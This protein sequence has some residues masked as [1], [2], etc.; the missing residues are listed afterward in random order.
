MPF[1]ADQRFQPLIEAI[2]S[3]HLQP[4]WV[5]SID[6]D[7]DP[8]VGEWTAM[9]AADPANEGVTRSLLL[10]IRERPHVAYHDDGYGQEAI[11]SYEGEDTREELT[12]TYWVVASSGNGWREPMVA[13]VKNELGAKAKRPVRTMAEGVAEVASLIGLDPSARV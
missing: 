7:S 3:L 5:V 4:S 8:E 6:T 9:F 13:C 10:T 2:R 11:L 12:R 1:R